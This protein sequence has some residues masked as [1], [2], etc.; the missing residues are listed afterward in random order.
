MMNRHHHGTK[1][2]VVSHSRRGTA[3][4]S[5][6]MARRTSATRRCLPLEAGSCLAMPCDGSAYPSTHALSPTRGGELP[7]D[8]LR[9]L[10]VPQQQGAVSH[11]RRGA[12]LRHQA[13][14]C[15]ATPDLRSP[16]SL[17]RRG[18]ALRRLSKM[19]AAAR[20][21]EFVS[22]SRR[23]TALRRLRSAAPSC[24]RTT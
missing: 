2:H 9:W 15:L 14:N 22:L 6:P 16:V 19:L 21:G 24:S 17:S 12:A 5:P 1:V 4:R 13:G 20:R 23:G 8:A 10:G 11:S 3:L 18:T 7:C